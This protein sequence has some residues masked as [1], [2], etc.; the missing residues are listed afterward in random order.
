[1][2]IEREDNVLE[3]PT[4]RLGQF[5]KLAGLVATGGEAK[6]LIQTG[7]VSV[8]GQVETR[9]KRQL[10]DGDTVALDDEVLIVEFGP[11]VERDVDLGQ[12]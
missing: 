2:S 6:N 8:N 4:I 12:E 7:K 1:V 10:R 11:S 3:E 5:L 9:R